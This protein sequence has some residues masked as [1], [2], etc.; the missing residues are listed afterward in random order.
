M[1]KRFSPVNEMG[2]A[3]PCVLASDHDA[4]VADLA[5]MTNDRN[6]HR[7]AAIQQ[8]VYWRTH[9]E[10]HIEALETALRDIA[11]GEGPYSM[12]PTTMIGIAKAA[13]APSA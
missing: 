12:D 8:S 2:E 10:A 9:H 6:Y 13:L 3:I 5:A 4:L 1:V 7:A 11:E